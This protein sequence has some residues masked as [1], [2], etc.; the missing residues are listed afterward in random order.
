[1]GASKHGFERLT[2]EVRR[3]AV[4][5]VDRVFVAAS[6]KPGDRWLA[7]ADHGEDALARGAVDDGSE[8]IT[9][10]AMD[11]PVRRVGVPQLAGDQ[12]QKLIA[13]WAPAGVVDRLRPSTCRR[14]M[15]REP[16][17]AP[18]SSERARP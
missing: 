10:D 2:G 7:L 14:T 17:F 15:A 5:Q 9:P 3:K 16:V 18:W 13:G 4:R 12:V 8:L 11:G 1:M 6:R